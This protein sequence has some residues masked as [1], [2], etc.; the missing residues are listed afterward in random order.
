VKR[1]GRVTLVVLLIIALVIVSGYGVITMVPN[2]DVGQ[3]D[4]WPSKVVGPSCMT[5]ARERHIP[6]DL[7]E[8]TCEAIKS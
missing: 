8:H 1:K 5:I 2:S 4:D 6:P 3:S 7:A